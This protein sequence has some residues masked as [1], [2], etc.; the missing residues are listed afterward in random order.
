HSFSYFPVNGYRNSSG[1]SLQNNWFGSAFHKVESFMFFVFVNA[2]QA[3]NVFRSVEALNESCGLE[4][5]IHLILNNI[6]KY[7]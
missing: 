1:E 7:T 6:E 3:E 2:T 4:S 5:R